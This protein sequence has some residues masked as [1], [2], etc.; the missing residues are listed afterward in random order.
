[1]LPHMASITAAGGLQTKVCYMPVAEVIKPV[2]F[3]KSHGQEN[4]RPA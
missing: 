3:S 4:G 2:P 1:V